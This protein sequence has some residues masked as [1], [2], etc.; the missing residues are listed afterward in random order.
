M[1]LGY[2][3]LFEVFLK[4]PVIIIMRFIE[5]NVLGPKYIYIYKFWG[6]RRGRTYSMD[7]FCLLFKKT[8]KVQEHDIY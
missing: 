1:K 4:V 6:V 3:I 7:I 8:E 5:N 2:F